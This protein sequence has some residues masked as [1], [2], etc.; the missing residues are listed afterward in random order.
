MGKQPVSFRAEVTQR[1][2]FLIDQHGLDGPD[3]SELLLP[4]VTYRDTGLMISIH[5]HNDTH[6]SAGE[7]ISVSIWLNTAD[8]SAH[9]DLDDLVEAAVF[10]PRHRVASKAH[11]GDAVRDTLDDNATWVRR[12]M[13]ILRGPGALD[14]I[15][16]ANRQEVDKAG[17]PKRR[18]RNIKW[19]YG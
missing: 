10:A 3:Y 19:K 13:P 6:D 1:F 17:N 16:S 12:L 7:K 15:R 18:P 9:A 11:T 8:G 2:Q 5:L 14:A 4:S